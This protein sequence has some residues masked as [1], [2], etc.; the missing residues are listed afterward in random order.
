MHDLSPCRSQHNVLGKVRFSELEQSLG[1]G[2]APDGLLWELS[3]RDHVRPL[4]C[5]QYDW[6]HCLVVQGTVVLEINLALGKLSGY[7][8][9]PVAIKA[10]LSLRL[11]LV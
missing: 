2:Y 3:L 6:M 11:C 7:G 5:L 1:L 10:W 9:T 8:F 4:Q